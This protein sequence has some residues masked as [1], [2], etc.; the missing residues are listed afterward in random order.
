MIIIACATL[1]LMRLPKC[2][3]LIDVTTKLVDSDVR[4][5]K[6]TQSLANVAWGLACLNKL[7]ATT[8]DQVCLPI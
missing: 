7:S 4:L 6:T 8:L 5:L 1:D 2:R 3:Q